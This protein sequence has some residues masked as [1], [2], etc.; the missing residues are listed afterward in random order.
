MRSAFAVLSLS[1]SAPQAA[2]ILSSSLAAA[3]ARHGAGSQR[4]GDAAPVRAPRGCRG[5]TGRGTTSG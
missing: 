2:M 5:P 3:A 1:I 4:S